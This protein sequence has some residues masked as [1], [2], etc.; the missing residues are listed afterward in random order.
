MNSTTRTHKFKRLFLF[1]NWF[2]TMVLKISGIQILTRLIFGIVNLLNKYLRLT[3]G[4]WPLPP[5]QHT[6][7][8]FNFKLLIE[9]TKSNLSLKYIWLIRHEWLLTRLAMKL[10]KPGLSLE[11]QKMQYL[12]IFSLSS[13]LLELI[14]IYFIR[15]SVYSE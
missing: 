15:K 10:V 9:F 1:K 8:I 12:G 5:T 4:Q 6:T 3:R 2:Y 11:F 7:Q 14:F 13:E